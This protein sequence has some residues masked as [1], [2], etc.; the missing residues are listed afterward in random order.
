MNI[1]LKY[2]GPLIILSIVNPILAAEVWVKQGAPGVAL[3]GSGKSDDPYLVAPDIAADYDTVVSSL[4]PNTKLHLGAGL[5]L[6]SGFTA[7]VVYPDGTHVEGD[8]EGV[9]TVRLK[10]NAIS[11]GQM[12]NTIHV[13]TS[14]L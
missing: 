3:T 5:F 6:T 13:G 10:A 12:T 14:S 9:T 1:Y 8:G 4:S 2:L 7:G 11:S